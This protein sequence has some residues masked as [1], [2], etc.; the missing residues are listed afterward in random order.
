MYAVDGARDLPERE[1]DHLPG[2]GGAR[3]VRIG[4]GAVDQYQADV[5]G[6][7]LVAL[8]A[9]RRAGIAEDRFSWP[10]QRALLDFVTEHWD[11][12]DSGIWEMRGP[13]QF[14]THSRVMV[15]AALDR[16]VR[17][18]REG[19]MEGPVQEWEAL[20]EKIR[21]EVMEHGVDRGS[22]GRPG[23][24]CFVQHYGTREV[25]A[26]LLQL[27]QVGFVEPDHPAML[28]TVAAVES[29]LM[30]D[31]L[32]LRYRTE[33]SS[34]GLP[35][36]S[37][38]SWPAR[39]GWRSS[40]PGPAA[41]TTGTRW[42]AGSWAWRTTSGCCPRSTTSRGAAS[43]ATPPRRCRTWRWCAPRVPWTLPTPPQPPLARTTSPPPTAGSWTGE[44]ARVVPVRRD[45]G[46]P[47]L[48][49]RGA[50]QR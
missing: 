27:S 26:S 14:F 19:G 34:D 5:L 45:D 43:S 24:G 12:K 4:N 11:R 8:D 22:P 44:P 47:L 1:L 2:Y 32:V 50:R 36:G 42:C 46:Q 29:D 41:P 48:P 18:V 17:A 3:P 39:S 25:D 15:W 40:T 31:G 16:G 7:V 28:A 37:T 30:P 23:R 6:E 38:R 13:E 20:R 33:A 35:P 49:A 10:M 9:A 21:D